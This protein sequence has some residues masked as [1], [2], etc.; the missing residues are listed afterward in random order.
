MGWGQIPGSAAGTA[1]VPRPLSS[2]L[3]GCQHR[4]PLAATHAPRLPQPP[5]SGK[6]LSG[7]WVLGQRSLGASL[8]SFSPAATHRPF[9]HHS[10]TVWGEQ[11]PHPK[12]LRG[13]GE[14]VSHQDL[15]FAPVQRQLP[16]CPP[17]PLKPLHKGHPQNTTGTPRHQAPHCAWDG[18]RWSHTQG[19]GCLPV[20]SKWTRGKSPE[21]EEGRGEAGG[22]YSV[23]CRRNPSKRQAP[24]EP[25]GPRRNRSSVGRDG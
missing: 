12:K 4:Q 21:R 2:P 16:H 6:D 7:P 15:A 8:T 9:S 17:H 25:D 13:R 20:A 11:C 23:D 1:A 22:E 14:G 18:P 3:P 19:Q 10:A 24:Q 5:L